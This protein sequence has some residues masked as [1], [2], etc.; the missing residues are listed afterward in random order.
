LIGPNP[1]LPE[2]KH[3]DESATTFLGANAASMPDSSSN[4]SAVNIH[5]NPMTSTMLQMNNLSPAK[6][7][8]TQGSI[9]DI[10]DW[11]LL[12]HNNI[13]FSPGKFIGENLRSSKEAKISFEFR[14]VHSQMDVV[15][16][17]KC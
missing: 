16:R 13:H 9:I 8:V 6:F 14:I 2:D 15:Q 11:N 10:K 7:S 12:D 3:F 1:P 4:S 17:K 5:N